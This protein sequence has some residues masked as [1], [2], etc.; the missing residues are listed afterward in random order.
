LV[1]RLRAAGPERRSA[2]MKLSAIAG[3]CK[4]GTCPTVYETDRGTYVV[5]GYVVTDA[6]AL[7]ALGLPAGESAV[8][9]PRDLLAGLAGTPKR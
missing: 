1:A 6:E 4:N 5:Q 2:D 3:N 9:I 7:A 8:E